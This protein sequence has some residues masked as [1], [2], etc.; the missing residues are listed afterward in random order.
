MT[1]YWDK[2]ITC[3]RVKST[4]L[5]LRIYP[6]TQW[7]TCLVVINT[8]R[9]IKL[10]QKKSGKKSQDNYFHDCLTA[11]R[12][13]FMWLLLVFFLT[14]CSLNINRTPRTTREQNSPQNQK[15]W[16]QEFVNTAVSAAPFHLTDCRFGFMEKCEKR[17]PLRSNIGSDRFASRHEA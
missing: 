12:G 10:L 13:S 2:W 1:R 17:W 16:L 4:A 9:M 7:S 3:C 5:I 11:K 8:K 15:R 6:P 14:G